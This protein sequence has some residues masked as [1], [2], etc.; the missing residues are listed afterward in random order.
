M[1]G[2]KHGSHFTGHSLQFWNSIWL[3]LALRLAFR[4]KVS[5]IE[6]F[7]YFPKLLRATYGMRPVCWSRRLIYAFPT[8]TLNNIFL[9][10]CITRKF[11]TRERKLFLRL[12]TRIYFY[13]TSRPQFRGLLWLS[14]VDSNEG[15]A[16]CTI[17]PR[18]PYVLAWLCAKFLHDKLPSNRSVKILLT[19]WIYRYRRFLSLNYPQN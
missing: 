16:R 18:P 4:P 17:M 11:D 3:T 6:G 9:L 10:H 5:Q 19:K 14:S 13:P 15:R 2:P 12:N 7:G 8:T 1:A